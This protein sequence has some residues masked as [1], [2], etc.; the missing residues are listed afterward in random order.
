MTVDLYHLGKKF[1]FA[2]F[3]ILSLLIT[4]SAFAQSGAIS[5]RVVDKTSE[6]ALPGANVI[7]EGTSFGAATNLD[8]EFS[9][10]SIPVG[11]YTLIVSYIGYNSDS[12]QV[13]VTADRTL[14]QNFSLLGKSVE[15]KEVVVTAQASGQRQAINQQLTSNTIINVVSAEKIHQLPDDNAATA[16][17]RLP[18]VSLMNG[19]QVVIRGVQAKLNQILLNGIELPSTDMNNRSTGLGFISSNLLS[20]I[21]VIKAI[22]PDMDANALGG[23]VNLRLR[24]APTGFHFDALASGSYNSTDHIGN[25]YKFWASVSNRFLDDKLGVF[26][27]GNLDRS[28]G[29]NQRAAISPTLL[30]QGDRTFGQ[31]TYYTTAAQYEYDANI[32]KNNGGSLILDYRLPNGKIVLQNTY[33]GNVTDQLNNYML[34]NF[35][36][37]SA[38]YTP[39]RSLYGKDLW[40]NALQLENTFGD[41]KVEASLSHSFTQQYTRYAYSPAL[42]G[43]AW[44]E[45][46]NQTG[47]TNPF[48]VDASGQRITYTGLSQQENMSLNNS[49]GVFNNLSQTDFFNNATIGGW[50]QSIARQFKQHLYNGSLDV[51]AP[52]SFSKDITATFK[53]GGKYIRTTRINNVDEFFAHSVDDLYRNPEANKYL[54]VSAGNPL[55]FSYVMDNFSRGQYYLSDLYNFTNGGFK[56]S[57]DRN[58]YDTWLKLSEQDWAVPIQ[59]ADSYKN[60]WNGAEQFSAA[61]LM[62]T[63]NIGTKMTLL[64]GARFESYNMIY[65]AQVTYVTHTVFGDCASTEG[66]SI[67][68]NDSTNPANPYYT[69]PYSAFNVDRTDNNLFP[70]VQLRYEFN[71]WSDLRL[72]YTTGISR[73]DYSAIIPKI[74]FYKGNFELGNPLLKPSKAQNFDIIASFHN[75]SIGLFTVNVFYKIIKDEMYNTSIYYVN[76]DQYAASTYIPDSTFMAQHFLFTVP[77]DQTIGISLNNP[78]DGY[79]RGVEIDWQTNFWYLPGL[80]SSLVLDV[81]YTK[82]GSNTSYTVL[83]PTKTQAINPNTGRPYNI[84]TTESSSYDGRLIQQ[85][86]D[87]VNVALGADHKGFHAR[88]SFS[89]TGNVINSIGTRPEEAA[90]TGN[91]Y[92][93]DFLIKQELPI[94]GLSVSLNG[95]NIFHNGIKT[96]RNYRISPDAPITKNLISVLYSPSV[97]AMNLRYS[98]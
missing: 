29:G 96:Y 9:I 25:N 98:F 55:K 36:N 66:G 24:E 16:L 40:I 57:L 60:D 70:D 76:R 44:S 52:V 72:A 50:T 68:V 7:I 69:V 89:M 43:A 35:N 45:F 82:S 59:Y 46:Y 34:L 20:G 14:E 90:F 83:T 41:I 56:Y 11:K 95:V 3:L 32:D 18:G 2:F 30:L 27:Q 67:V 58:K 84:Y 97:F 26:V 12:V 61:Y 4:T 75:N 15:S 22:T 79:I 33:A 13:E 21:E 71:D 1:P 5:G 19:D 81:N 64:G 91:I 6:A 28:D 49:L 74:A 80:L 63:F 53:A 31:G 94:D 93:W 87:V 86:N 85:A 77:N 78:N 92:R 62:G 65:H 8:G 54:G 47:T 17:S 38:I 73:P 48:G 23:V 10:R 51:T 88:I 42:Y 37:T 39:D